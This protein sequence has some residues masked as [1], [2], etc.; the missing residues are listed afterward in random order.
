MKD[1][2]LEPRY[3]S[4]TA[5][6]IKNFKINQDFGEQSEGVL[7][8]YFDL[9]A[10]AEQLTAGR[11]NKVYKINLNGTDRVIKIA[12]GLYRI[13]ELEREII[14]MKSLINQGCGHIVPNISTY[15]TLENSAYL[16]EEYIEG[17]IA[18]ESLWKCKSKKDKFKIW[19]RLG[20][21]LSEIHQVYRSDDINC[22]WIDGQL[23]MAKINMETNLL[24]IEEFEKDT[25]E[26]M[27]EWL[28]SNKPKQRQSSLLHGD[29]RTKNI[30]IENK[31]SL[32]VIDWGFVDIG[33]PYYDLAIID[34]YFEDNLDRESFYIGYK[35][36]NY[37]KKLIDYYIKLSKF[38]NI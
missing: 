36:N 19:E 6:I 8:G 5:S 38:I 28:S 23:E 14:V 13:T 20:Q 29:Y 7:E 1:K 30:I 25:P 33:D 9:L 34:Y 10:E 37:N 31:E 18:R 11:C 26:D 16:I 15:E 24:D 17:E 27:L 21:A 32:K 4:I 2:L 12:S 3:R 22:S 35:K